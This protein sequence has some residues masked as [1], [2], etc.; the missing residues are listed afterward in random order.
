M[1]A[2]QLVQNERLTGE[3]FGTLTGITATITET[4]GGDIMVTLSHWPKG[5]EHVCDRAATY[6][7]Q[8]PVS[9]E[10]RCSTA[11]TSTMAKGRRLSSGATSDA[12]NDTAGDGS[13]ERQSKCATK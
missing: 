8:P 2:Q 13:V 12:R 1:Q 9:S 6:R 11:Q 5:E 7:A 4:P 10:E 3:L